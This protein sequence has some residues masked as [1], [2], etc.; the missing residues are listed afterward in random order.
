MTLGIDGLR[1]RAVPIRRFLTPGFQFLASREMTG[2]SARPEVS[3]ERIVTSGFV[4][5]A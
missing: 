3:S 1:S 5:S 2:Q 4:I